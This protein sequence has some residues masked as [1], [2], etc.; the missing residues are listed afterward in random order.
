MGSPTRR[1][2]ILA[3]VEKGVSV[4]ARSLLEVTDDGWRLMP[5]PGWHMS[6]LVEMVDRAIAS[7]PD[8]AVYPREVE[9]ILVVTPRERLKWTKDGRLAASDV[10]KAYFR[11]RSVEFRV[12]DPKVIEDA[13]DRDLPSI[14]REE[15]LATATENRER[16]ARRSAMTRKEGRKPEGITVRQPASQVEHVTQPPPGFAG[17]GEFD[18]EGWLR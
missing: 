3:H 6:T 18:R 8:L 10:R 7:V 1:E 11:G 5:D 4:G 17:W 14:W 2:A 16:G 13:L 15:D 12:H 9:E